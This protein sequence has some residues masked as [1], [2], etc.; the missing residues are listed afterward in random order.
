MDTLNPYI[1][2]TDRDIEIIQNGISM[3][4]FSLL[5]QCILMTLY[6]IFFIYLNTF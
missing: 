1:L 6:E 4:W 3:A 2:A 5:S